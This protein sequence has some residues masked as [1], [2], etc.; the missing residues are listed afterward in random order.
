V[1]QLPA[2]QVRLTRR[3]DGTVVLTCVRADGSSTW[4]RHDKHGEFFSF[5]DLRHFAVEETLGIQRGFFGLIAEGWDI[6][7][8]EGKGPRGAVPADAVLAEHMVG[9]LDRERVGGAPPLTAAEV[10]AHLAEIAAGG[11]AAQ[12]TLSDAELDAVRQRSDALHTAWAHTAPG[13]TLELTFVRGT[14][15]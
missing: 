7:D 9:L 1:A 11:R 12:R 2:L 14:A 4:Q 3:T 6:A 15:R 13:S 5:H 8:T 10:N